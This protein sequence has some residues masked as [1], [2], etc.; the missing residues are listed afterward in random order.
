[1]S[2]EATLIG[3]TI[4]P[5]LAGIS[6]YLIA[7]R[8]EY[9]SPGPLIILG[10]AAAL[11]SLLIERTMR[12]TFEPIGDSTWRAI[13]KA[14]LESSLCEESTKFVVFLLWLA[15]L[16]R[17]RPQDALVGSVGIA[18][19]YLAVENVMALDRAAGVDEWLAIIVERSLLTTPS[20]VADA[21]QVGVWTA[22]VIADR[23]SGALRRIASALAAA[24]LAHGLWDAPL[25]V[26]KQRDAAGDAWT[27]L[28]WLPLLLPSV[29]VQAA[30]IIPG[31]RQL[32]RRGV[33]LRWPFSTAGS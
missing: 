19:S 15:L 3:A 30:S 4:V 2:P 1:M 13:A 29:V 20:T 12:A 16:H 6:I 28:Q 23:G 32:D 31:V 25:L 11:A 24:V 7:G 5:L 14:F 8:P 33:R 21:L 9:R 26:A 22:V 27:L 18:V 10:V 17:R